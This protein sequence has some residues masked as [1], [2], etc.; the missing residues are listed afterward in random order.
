MVTARA[1]SEKR[2]PRCEETLSA[3]AFYSCPS[4]RDGLSGYCKVCSRAKGVEDW[5]TASPEKLEARR[6]K[7]RE[8]ARMRAATDPEYH[9]QRREWY[10]ANKDRS[11]ES[12]YRS[13]YG[14]TIA[15][16][17]KMLMAQGGGCAICRSTPT[18]VL[19]VDHCHE[20]GVVRGLLCTSCNSAL[21]ALGDSPAGLRR[22]LDY[23][24][25]SL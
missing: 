15:D 24:E 21:G 2:C 20:T 7:E 13:R 10:H 1:L 23:L 16:Y 18:T 14:I 25:G 6:R 5:R 12:S 4:T 11:R 8:R 9:A 17:E 22:A 3:D 19:S